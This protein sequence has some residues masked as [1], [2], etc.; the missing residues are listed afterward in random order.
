[1]YLTGEPKNEANMTELKG[2]TD[3]SAIIMEDFNIPLSKWILTEL[4]RRSVR[5][6]TTTI[7]QLDLIDIYRTTYSTNG[8]TCE[9]T[10]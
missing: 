4:G 9:H 1:M 10:E 8:M 5:R 6:L 7:N 3:N 2:E